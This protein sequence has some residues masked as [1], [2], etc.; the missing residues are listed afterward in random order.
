MEPDEE[1]IYY[2]WVV[3]GGAFVVMLVGFGVAYSFGA[4]FASFQREFAADR[5]SVS[6]AFSLAAF[7]YFSLGAISGPL[8]DRIGPRRV[9]L[10]GVA[11]MVLGLALASQAQT[12]WQIYLAY[13]VGVGVG[14][15]F[16]YVPA[17]GA[18]QG[19]FGRRRGLAS[20]LAV[21]G[22]GLGTLAA[23]PL[24][25]WL[26]ELGGW[27]HAYVVFAVCVAVF[28][29]ASS[30]LLERGSLRQVRKPTPAAAEIVGTV[31]GAAG[32][33]GLRQALS[34]SPFWLLY[35][36]CISTSMGLFIPFVH[37]VSYAEDK[38]LG[39]ETGVLMIGL[40]GAGSIAGRFVLG[41]AADRLG[42]KRSLAGSFAGMAVMLLW[43]LGAVDAWSL[44]VFAFVFG[45]FYGGFVA[46][47]PAMTADYFGASRVSGVIGA[48]YTG[49]G[50]GALIGPIMAGAAYDMMGS[51]TLPI[52]GGAAANLLATLCM[53]L[54]VKPETW[55]EA[56]MTSPSRA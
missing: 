13:G 18:V 22:I 28:G 54:I 8:A 6:L 33:M 34:S 14:V 15:G 39:A 48:L 35:A 25:L 12:L 20:G 42:R 40:I 55:R 38:G 32:D 10:G 49:A 30:L 31:H 41:G 46:L 51:Y 19:W 16:T 2:G 24:A 21:A 44:G 56:R 3:V 7:L 45:V 4:F 27:R 52:V 1:R 50:I 36:A 47:I 17:I 29:V 37:L 43:W 5:A 53:V 9:A 11:C 23:A 26:I